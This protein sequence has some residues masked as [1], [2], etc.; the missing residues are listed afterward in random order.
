MGRAGLEPATRCL[1]DPAGDDQD[2]LSDC[3]L[4]ETD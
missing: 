4:D 2:T 1:K 3:F